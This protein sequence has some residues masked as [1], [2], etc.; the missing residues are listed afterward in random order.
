MCVCQ[1]FVY[2]PKY[3]EL[4]YL[5]SSFNMSRGYVLHVTGVPTSD[6]RIRKGIQGECKAY[7]DRAVFP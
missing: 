1:S 7:Q 4:P 2:L 5:D 6:I 3:C